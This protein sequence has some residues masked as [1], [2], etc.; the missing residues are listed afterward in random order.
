[1]YRVNMNTQTFTHR[2]PNTTNMNR[3]EAVLAA[4]PDGA[5][6]DRVLPLE[7]VIKFMRNAVALVEPKAEQSFVLYAKWLSMRGADMSLTQ[8]AHLWDNM[9]LVY[10]RE[11]GTH[12]VCWF[13]SGR[14]LHTIRP[15]ALIR[16]WWAMLRSRISG[17]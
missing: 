7:V 13:R 1:M 12:L 16:T 11:M 6:L 14:T 2:M 10:G 5:L 3:E 4:M 17:R 15:T 9:V 8:A